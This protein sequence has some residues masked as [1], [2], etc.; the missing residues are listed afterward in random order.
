MTPRYVRIAPSEP[1]PELSACAPFRAVVV[2]DT[3]YSAEWEKLATKWLV[4]SGCLYMLAW[5]RGCEGWHDAVDWAA[6]EKFHFGDIPDD[7]FVMTTWHNEETLE[8]VFWFAGACAH[9]P[10]IELLETLLV[11]VG[12]QNRGVEFIELFD[13]AETLPEREP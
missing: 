10:D 13:R 8:S 4:D 5:G 1:F 7:Q 6:L 3:A 2:L 9:H 12:E 11:D